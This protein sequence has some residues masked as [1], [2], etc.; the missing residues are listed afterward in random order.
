MTS[1]QCS[2]GDGQ[3]LQCARVGS[4]AFCLQRQGLPRAGE[5]VV[6]YS[7][8]NHISLLGALAMRQSFR[9]EAWPWLM[10]SVPIPEEAKPDGV[11]A[12]F[13]Q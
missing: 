13:R 8:D 3:V 11:N 9:G 10:D 5:R 4:V 1:A 12:D 2:P 7:D 6:M